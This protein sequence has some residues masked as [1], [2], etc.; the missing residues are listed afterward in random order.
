[1]E[2]TTSTRG[3]VQIMPQTDSP[4]ASASDAAVTTDYDR[5]DHQSEKLYGF[6]KLMT[7][8]ETNRAPLFSIILFG[9]MDG[10]LS[11]THP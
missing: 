2:S 11:K 6:S 10:T 7:L 9:T 1:M 3:E 8:V 5:Y 4:L